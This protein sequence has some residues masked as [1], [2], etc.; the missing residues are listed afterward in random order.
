MVPL[1][2]ISYRGGIATFAVPESWVEEYEPEGGGT[3]YDD[4]EGAGTLRL[5][6][7]SFKSNGGQS[8]EQIVES[9]VHDK[10]FTRGCSENNLAPH[11][12]LFAL[13]L[14]NVSHCRGHL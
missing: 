3:F 7:L 10:E 6:V 12:K 1:K 11:Y 4:V 8:S 2:T 5:N 13:K 9:F 14:N